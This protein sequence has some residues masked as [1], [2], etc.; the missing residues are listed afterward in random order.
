VQGRR[1]A[2]SMLGGAATLLATAAPSFAAYGVS[3]TATCCTLDH[4][5]GECG[6]HFEINCSKWQSL[7]LYCR[8][9]IRQHT[10]ARAHR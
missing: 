1:A 8:H 10:A 7:M 4:P 6:V 3:T 2:L 9:V 5:H